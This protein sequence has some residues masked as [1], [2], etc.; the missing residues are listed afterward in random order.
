VLAEQP[1]NGPQDLGADFGI[2]VADLV[3]VFA[4]VD[5][6]VKFEGLFDPNREALLI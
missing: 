1:G 2:V 4:G 3:E 5:L 6:T